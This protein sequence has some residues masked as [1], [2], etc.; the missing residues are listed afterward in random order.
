MVEADEKTTKATDLH[1]V[2]KP[3]GL[4]MAAERLKERTKPQ[5]KGCEEESSRRPNRFLTED[6]DGLL[7]SL[8]TAKSAFCSIFSLDQVVFSR[9]RSLVQNLVLH[10]KQL[11]NEQENDTDGAGAVA[12]RSL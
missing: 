9:F 12:S 3:L 10:A 1:S 5:E 8:G 11:A 7:V 4:S 6:I 2:T